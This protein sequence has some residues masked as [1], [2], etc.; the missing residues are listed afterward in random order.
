MKRITF[1][2][3]FATFLLSFVSSTYAINIDLDTLTVDE[4]KQLKEIVDT[5][6][7][8]LGEYH[9]FALERNDRG[10]EVLSLQNRL[11][12]LDFY[13]FEPSG[14]YDNNTQIAMK[15]FEKSMQLEQD[16]IASI[17]DQKILFSITRSPSVS[18]T[19]APNQTNSPT[20]D[21]IKNLYETIDYDEYAR[22]PEEHFRKKVLLKGKVLQVL[23]SRKEGF[24][25]RLS[26][27]N[28]SN[29]IIFVFI[30]EDPG[31]N[32]LEND[33]LYVYAQLDK[34][35]TYKSIWDQTIVIPAAIADFIELR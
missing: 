10:P 22:Y 35:I 27:L 26:V 14:K 25:I 31:F 6:L 24:Q 1:L 2:I 21:P 29:N 12:M 33:Q 23:G 8:E 17:E 18:N 13:N 3:L 5:K 19:P 16:G 34:T 11:K 28:N 4:L 30:N 20:I 15:R 7:I 9:F 32:I